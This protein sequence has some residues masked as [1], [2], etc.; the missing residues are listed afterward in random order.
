LNVTVAVPRAL[1]SAFEVGIVG[2]SFAKANA[3][4][5][6]IVFGCVF[7]GDDGLLPHAAASIPAAAMIAY[8]F[9]VVGSL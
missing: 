3:A 9:I 4:V 6:T 8:R 1:A 5:K 7:D 2:I